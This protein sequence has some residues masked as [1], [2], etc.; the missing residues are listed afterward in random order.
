M[1]IFQKYNTVGNSNS[2]RFQIKGPLY[3][4]II[5]GAPDSGFGSPTS[6]GLCHSI[7]FIK[8]HIIFAYQIRINIRYFVDSK[9]SKYSSTPSAFNPKNVFC[10]L[11]KNDQQV[12]Q[13]TCKVVRNKTL[14]NPIKN[15][16]LKT[17]FFSPQ[18]AVMVYVRL[19]FCDRFLLESQ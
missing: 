2:T 10:C 16:R 11:F 6:L 1:A 8:V 12:I 4:S 5:S 19:V 9:K 13:N 18:T 7:K 14:K 3:F 17:I 15:V